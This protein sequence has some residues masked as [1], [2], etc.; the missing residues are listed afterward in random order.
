MLLNM[1]EYVTMA[2]LMDKLPENITDLPLIKMMKAFALAYTGKLNEAEAILLED[3]SEIP[4]IR[5]GENSTS[6]LYIYIQQQKAV[7]QGK[8]LQDNEI[9]VPFHLDLRMSES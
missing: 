8:V 4:D 5:E 3:I 6:Q 2:E 1:Q 7:R 9:K